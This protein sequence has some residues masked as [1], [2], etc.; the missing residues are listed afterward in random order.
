MSEEKYIPEQDQDRLE[1]FFNDGAKGVEEHPEHWISGGDGGIS[2][3]YECAIKEV[4]RLSKENPDEYY[5]VD[6]GWGNCNGDSQAFCEDCGRLLDNDFTQYACE[7]EVDHF[8][9]YGF[10]IESGDD[11]LAMSKVISSA[12]WRPITKSDPD[13][14]FYGK[15]HRLCR[16]ILKST[17]G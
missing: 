4:E 10:D 12:G 16:K 6:G 2:Y 11:C 5:S 9:E 17:E 7:T 8:I 15:L 13:I 3:C 14:E 1:K